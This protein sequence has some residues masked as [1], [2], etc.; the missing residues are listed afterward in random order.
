P[1]EKRQDMSNSLLNG[2][3]TRSGSPD[4]VDDQG[5]VDDL[6]ASLGF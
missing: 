5:Q 6:L 4:A 3:Q 1:L 2:P